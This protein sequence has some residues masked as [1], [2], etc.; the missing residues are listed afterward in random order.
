MTWSPSSIEYVSRLNLPTLSDW[1]K[2]AK[3]RI[4]A[5]DARLLAQHVLQLSH[6][7]LICDPDKT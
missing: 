3:S 2:S 6:A 1:L 4:D 5:L 7:E